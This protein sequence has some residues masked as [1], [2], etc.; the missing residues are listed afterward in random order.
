MRAP[1]PIRSR[2]RQKTPPRDG[3][4]RRGGVAGLAMIAACFA[5]GYFAAPEW[6]TEHNPFSP[7]VG[8][9]GPSLAEM[10]AGSIFIASMNQDT[11][12]QRSFDNVN[13]RQWDIGLVDCRLAILASRQGPVDRMNAITDAFRPK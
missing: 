8:Q 10:R 4:S 11:C 9:G 6:V 12:W 2:R 5:I 3:R 1:Q 13:G 7:I